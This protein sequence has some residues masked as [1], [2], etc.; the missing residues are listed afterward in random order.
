MTAIFFFNQLCLILNQPVGTP[1][2]SEQ[3]ENCTLLGE[4]P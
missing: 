1:L 3:S 4:I 2:V